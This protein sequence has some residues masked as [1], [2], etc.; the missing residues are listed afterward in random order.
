VHDYFRV[1]TSLEPVALRQQF[2]SELDKVI[3]LAIEDDLD[4]A[5]LVGLGLPATIEVDDAET[6]VGERDGAANVEAVT[7]RS[8]MADS[9]VHPL[10]EAAIGSLPFEIKNSTYPTHTDFP[11]SFCSSMAGKIG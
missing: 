1:G 11:L 6:P 7:V 5:V 10:E 2:F 3:D 8:P 9:F 4:A